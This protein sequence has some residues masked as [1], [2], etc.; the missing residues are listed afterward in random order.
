MGHSAFVSLD[1]PVQVPVW[2][3]AVTVT[4]VQPYDD[5]ALSDVMSYRE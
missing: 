1:G 5:G 3:S 2:P 4:V